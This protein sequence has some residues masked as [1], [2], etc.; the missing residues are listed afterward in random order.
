M[1]RSLYVGTISGTSIDGLDLALV[2]AGAARPQIVAGATQPFDATLHACLTAAATGRDDGVDSVARADHLLGKFI[3][4]AVNAFLVHHGI[5]RDR[6]AAIGSHG[7]TIRHRPDGAT[8]FTCQIGDP[9]LIAE[10]TGITTVADF[11]RRDMA[12]GGQGAPLVPPFHAALFR[13]TQAV[14]VVV[15]IGGIGNITVLPA[16]PAQPITGFDTGPGN[17]LLDAWC[18]RHRGLPF[19]DAGQWAATGRVDVALLERMLTDA[20]FVRS[21]PKSTGK[22]YFHLDWLERQLAADPAL[23]PADVQ[24]TLAELT[25]CTIARGIVRWGSDRGRVIVCGGGRLNAD[26]MARLESALAQ[27]SVMP[28]EAAGVAGD[29]IEAAA[30]A[31]LAAL[32][33]ENRAGNEPAVTGAAGARVLGAIY[34]K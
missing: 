3:G 15:N 22:E 8:P 13:M 18:A 19:D 27:H 5:A 28:S 26:L 17:G 6:V 23:P 11:R 25:A 29:W 4:H 16:D 20:Y 12:A 32:T 21:P 14:T 2:D 10:I 1:T 24:A 34:L 31:W 33:L 9:T 30:F 7:Q